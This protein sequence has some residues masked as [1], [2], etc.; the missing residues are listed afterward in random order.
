MEALSPCWCLGGAQPLPTVSGMLAARWQAHIA[1]RGAAGKSCDMG[2]C[3][4]LLVTT[5]KKPLQAELGRADGITQQA[6]LLEELE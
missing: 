1:N 2:T 3:E 6:W 5:T 4:S